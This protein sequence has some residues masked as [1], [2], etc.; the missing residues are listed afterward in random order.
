MGNSPNDVEGMSRA[1]DAPQ[2][3]F[4]HINDQLSTE[5]RWKDCLIARAE[6]TVKTTLAVLTVSVSFAAFAL[7]AGLGLDVNL[8]T[9]G[10]ACLGLVAAVTAVI[11]GAFAQ[12]GRWHVAVTSNDTIAEFMTERYW[13]NHQV[14]SLYAVARLNARELFAIRKSNE[15][16]VKL[17]DRALW[18][19]VLAVLFAGLAVLA[20]VGGRVINE[21][22]CMAFGG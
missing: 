18:S 5:Y 6:T 2:V 8:L 9:T 20:E 21:L 22:G 7:G 15:D 14:D 10:F 13:R 17:C 16:R 11:L 1:T 12:S 4:D 3:Y 19:Q